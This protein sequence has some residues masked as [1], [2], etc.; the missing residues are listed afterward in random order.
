MSKSDMDSKKESTKFHFG[1]NLLSVIIVLSGIAVIL[2][3]IFF[4][5]GIINFSK[6]KATA[7]VTGEPVTT[8]STVDFEGKIF[9]DIEY[10]SSETD[11]FSYTFECT[12]WDTTSDNYDKVDFILKVTWKDSANLPL[13]RLN[14]T[15]NLKYSIFAEV[16]VLSNVGAYT[17]YSSI[18]TANINMNVNKGLVTLKF[19]DVEVEKFPKSTYEFPFFYKKELPQVYV[20]IFY[21]TDNQ[22]STYKN[23]GLKY[24]YTDLGITSGGIKA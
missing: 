21:F 13:F 18:S 19:T 2:F 7:F 24:N 9:N 11:L 16:C 10:I 20:D 12:D 3:A 23:Y 22:L 14:N 5:R 1:R 8:Y 15:D 4:V 17:K 6:N